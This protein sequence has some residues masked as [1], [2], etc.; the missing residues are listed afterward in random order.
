MALTLSEERNRRVSNNALQRR[1]F[2]PKLLEQTG[3]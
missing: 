1:I 2:G 3:D